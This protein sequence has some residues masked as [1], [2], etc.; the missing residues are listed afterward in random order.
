MYSCHHKLLQW[1]ILSFATLVVV[2]G[3]VVWFDLSDQIYSKFR[4]FRN[5]V[6]TD[7]YTSTVYSKNLSKDP[8]G[9]AIKQVEDRSIKQNIAW[10]DYIEQYLKQR[11]CHL[12]KK[13]IW[14]ILYY[15]VPEFRVKLSRTIKQELW[16]YDSK[17]YVFDDWTIKKYCE[18]YFICD[19]YDDKNLSSQKEISSENVMTSCKEFF[20][21]NYKWWE[22]NEKIL[23]NVEFSQAWDDKYWNNSTEDSPYDIMIDLAVIAKLLYRDAQ[24]PMMSV[25]YKMPNFG[26]A[27]KQSDKWE[28]STS[29]GESQTV[30]WWWDNKWDKNW[31]V[32]LNWWQSLNSN[33]WWKFSVSIAQ[34]DSAQQPVNLDVEQWLVNALPISNS[35]NWWYDKL[36]EGLSSVGLGSQDSKLFYNLCED[37]DESVEPD[38]V[39][40]SWLSWNEIK[41]DIIDFSNLSDEEY[42]NIIDSMINAVDKYTTL[43]SDIEDQIKKDASSRSDGI[44]NSTTPEDLEDVANKI[45]NCYSSCD[46]LRIDQK[47]SCML[48][49]ACW[50]IESPIFD[51]NKTPGLGPIFVIKFCGVPAVNTK[52]SVWGKRIHSIEE[53]LN[54]IYWVVDKLSREWKLLKWTQQHEFLDSSTKQM[55][56]ANTFAFSI[57]MELVD[58]TNNRSTHSDQFEQKRMQDLNEIWQINNL[59]A[60]NLNDASARNNNSIIWDWWTVSVL[61]EQ[62]P[63]AYDST[64]LSLDLIADSDA[65]RYNELE[66]LVANLFNQHGLMRKLIYSNI[67]ELNSYS[68]TLY[69]KKCEN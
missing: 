13:N 25:S 6:S 68:E 31:Q 47:A 15:F 59:I 50:E 16:D 36:V 32:S 3:Y 52:F 66:E 57:D 30:P 22:D 33:E 17:K 19:K 48:K 55:N 63:L 61:W 9:E 34:W 64:S 67:S 26:N 11:W 12:S 51:P 49:C 53:W 35:D 54:E 8:F 27:G 43:P 38:E 44:I 28:S 46:G 24:E 20:E 29:S 10:A 7:S 42:Q 65:N 4:D 40:Q 2:N 37:D 5:E 45:K 39:W 58:I 69:N 14:A 62:K 56:V 60:N 1:L 41:E 23:Q 18:E 21:S